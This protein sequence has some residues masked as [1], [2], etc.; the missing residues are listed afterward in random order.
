MNRTNFRDDF[1]ETA[2]RDS[3]GIKVHGRSL[4]RMDA[5]FNWQDGEFWSAICGLGK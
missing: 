2:I 4:V 3:T 5:G 1:H